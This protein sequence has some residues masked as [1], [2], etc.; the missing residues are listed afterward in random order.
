MGSDDTH[1]NVS[2]G[3]GGQSHKTVSA[4]H[5]LFEEKGEP[6]AVS[7]RGPS[8]YQPN[9][10]PLGQTGSSLPPPRYFYLSAPV[11]HKTAGGLLLIT[12]KDRNTAGWTQKQCRNFH[13]LRASIWLLPVPLKV[14]HPKMRSLGQRCGGV[15]GSQSVSG[16]NL[17]SEQC[18]RLL[19]TVEERTSC[20]KV[21]VTKWQ[22]NWATPGPKAIVTK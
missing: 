8:A 2:V 7:N 15:H 16:R 10:L 18:L 5:N 3:S 14:Q 4:N 11:R 12:H 6:Q 21:N 13:T 9:A 22:E 20:G 1:F 17:S 19:A